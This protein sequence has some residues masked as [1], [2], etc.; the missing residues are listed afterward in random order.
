MPT[1]GNG[2]KKV[3]EYTKAGKKKAKQYAKRTGKKIV[4]KGSSY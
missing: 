2:K 1:V 3:F 4:K